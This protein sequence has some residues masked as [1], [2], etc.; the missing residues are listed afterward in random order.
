[1]I[2]HVHFHS[3]VISAFLPSFDFFRHFCQCFLFN[4]CEYCINLYAV[5]LCFCLFQDSGSTFP[6]D[7]VWTDGS[8]YGV[9]SFTNWNTNE[10]D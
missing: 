10:P 2:R 5:E 8:D 9:T 3:H 6:G 7:F 1:M 4:V